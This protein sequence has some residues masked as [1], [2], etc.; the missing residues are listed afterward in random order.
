VGLA[1]AGRREWGRA[2]R[3]RGCASP[4]RA[5]VC[6]NPESERPRPVLAGPL[7]VW[8]ND[9]SSVVPGVSQNALRFLTHAFGRGAPDV[10][11]GGHTAFERENLMNVVADQRMECLQF[12]KAQIGQIAATG[13]A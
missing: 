3:R 10:P 12:G 8:K 4:V 6:T 11:A 9:D 7:H 13:F 2:V 5:W 1:S